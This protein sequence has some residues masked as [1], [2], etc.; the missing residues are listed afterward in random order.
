MYIPVIKNM[1]KIVF[2]PSRKSAKNT[3]CNLQYFL[4]NFEP[5]RNLVKLP[6]PQ[7]FMFDISY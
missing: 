7:L 4:L 1:K 3:I 5:F 2:A 6:Q